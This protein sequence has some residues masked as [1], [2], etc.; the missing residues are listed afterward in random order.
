MNA[1]RRHRA[2][3]WWLP[4]AVVGRAQ[5]GADRAL[6]NAQ[7]QLFR[8]LWFFLPEPAIARNLQFQHLLLSRFLSEAGQQTL[9]FGALVATARGGGSAL[10]VALVG[11]AA[12]A[13]PALLGLYGGAVADALPNRVA[14][15]GAYTGMAALCF[16]LPGLLGTDL[17]V[18][19]A[20]IF[21]V[22][23]LGQVS[24]P[25]ESSVLPLV[26]TEAELAS[27]ASM[28]NLAAAAGAG[29]G[30]ALFAPV[31]V[32]AF[33]VTPAVYLA[34]ALLLLAAS[35]VFDLPVGDKAWRRRIPVPRARFQAAVR[36]LVRHPA[37]GTMIVMSV[38]AGSVNVVLQTLAPHYVQSVL[39]SDATNTA[40]VFAPS[41]AGVVL[42]LV[43]APFL[44]GLRG[45]R[46]A[47][48]AGLFLA[49]ASLFL[50]GVVDE[51][52][53]AIDTVNPVHAAELVGIHMNRAMRTAGFLA[54]PLAFGVSLTATSVQTYINRRV[55][56]PYQ[57]R[58]FAMQSSLR[59]GASIVPLVALGAAAGQFGAEKVLLVSPLVLFAVGYGLVTVSFRFARL[60]PPPSQ[61]AVMESF[62]EE[63]TA[64]PQKRADAGG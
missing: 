18:V 42:A 25:T 43:A 19:L 15:A 8:V 41:A 46:I 35:R 53:R 4:F 14:L 39:D 52:G 37:V 21:A 6:D 28:I 38:L 44:M 20:L 27:A 10:E 26:A 13:S 12:L 33:G 5:V 22:N 30:T 9:A 61:L 32:K 47:A 17:I 24:A 16:A 1:K 56:I 54:L 40:Y 48:L 50:L 29:F 51:V 45:E 49:T 62:W 2:R 59:N 7:G 58:T 55:P 63:P 11:V 23:A 64:A 31:L 3:H 57:G 60:G 36:W 34:G